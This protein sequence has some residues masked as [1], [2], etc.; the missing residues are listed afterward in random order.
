MACA[1]PPPPPAPR[2]PGLAP[3]PAG[4]NYKKIFHGVVS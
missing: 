1:A 2:F 4:N 3:P